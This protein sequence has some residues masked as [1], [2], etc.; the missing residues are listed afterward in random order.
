MEPEFDVHTNDNIMHNI[1]SQPRGRFVNMTNAIYCRS[2][3]R[4]YNPLLFR[5]PYLIVRLR[6]KLRLHILVLVFGKLHT[7]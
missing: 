5:K 1:S 6:R 7:G 3:R 4:A 2:R